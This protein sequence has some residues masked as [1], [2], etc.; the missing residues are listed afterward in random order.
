[1]CKII[2][3]YKITL[4]MSMT[5]TRLIDCLNNSVFKSLSNDNKL[6]AERISLRRMFQSRGVTTEKFFSLVSVYHM[7]FDN[8]FMFM[9]G[10]CSGRAP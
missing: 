10:W 2:Q 6:V 9:Y 8:H 4:K 7:V 5:I 3:H 1:M